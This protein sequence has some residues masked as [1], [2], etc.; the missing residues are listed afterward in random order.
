MGAMKH[1]PAKSRVGPAK[2]PEANVCDAPPQWETSGGK[3]PAAVLLGRRGGLI[4]G[5]VRAQTLSAERRREIAQLA[6]RAR[7]SKK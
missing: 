7:W 5:K 6:A 1:A 2:S 3:N 4:G